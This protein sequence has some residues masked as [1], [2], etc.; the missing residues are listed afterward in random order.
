[1]QDIAKA[2]ASSLD[3]GGKV[4]LVNG[5]VTSGVDSLAAAMGDASAVVCATGYGGFDAGGFDKVDRL[6]SS[7]VCTKAQALG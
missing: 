2:Q 4:T 1:M 6:V 7:C 3:K 5:D